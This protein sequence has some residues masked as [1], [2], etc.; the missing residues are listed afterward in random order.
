MQSNR[1]TVTTPEPIPWADQFREA[2]SRLESELRLA[3]PEVRET[4]LLSMLFDTLRSAEQLRIEREG[5]P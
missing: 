5:R 2:F 4:A 1:T 3:K